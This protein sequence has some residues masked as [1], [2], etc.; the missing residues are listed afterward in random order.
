MYSKMEETN[1]ESL[2]EF[3]THD[4][5]KSDKEN[6]DQNA[7]INKPIKIKERVRQSIL[8]EGRSN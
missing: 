5:R 2:Y 8:Q 6:Q 1:S 7:E 3:Q 4:S